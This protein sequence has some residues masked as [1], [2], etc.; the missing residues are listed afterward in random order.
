MRI[1]DLMILGQVVRTTGCLFR[2]GKKLQARVIERGT[3]SA[4][5][6]KMGVRVGAEVEQL[7]RMLNEEKFP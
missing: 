3:D 7:W 5:Y 6:E 1:Y 2:K 4:Q